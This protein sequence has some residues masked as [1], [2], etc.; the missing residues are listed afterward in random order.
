MVVVVGGSR[1]S[2]TEALL[3]CLFLCS[4]CMT[5]GV[6]QSY[7]FGVGGMSY[8]GVRRIVCIFCLFRYPASKVVQLYNVSSVSQ[9]AA[10]SGCGDVGIGKEQ[11]MPRYLRTS[12]ARLLELFS[13]A[14]RIFCRLFLMLV[15]AVCG[16]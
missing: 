6:G 7:D 12:I 13:Y 8:E 11:R 15:G 4:I 16:C 10:F 9:W 2:V 14:Y 5:T 3:G 1:L